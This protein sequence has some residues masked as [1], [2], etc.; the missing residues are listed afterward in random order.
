MQIM[1]LLIVVSVCV[2]TQTDGPWDT[3]MKEPCALV[4]LS[5]YVWASLQWSLCTAGVAFMRMQV[6]LY[7][8]SL[9]QVVLYTGGLIQVVF[10]HIQVVFIHIQVVFIHIQVVLYR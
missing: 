2:Y 8:G 7:T 4:S 1:F 6:V 3:C 10:I 9:I 5:D